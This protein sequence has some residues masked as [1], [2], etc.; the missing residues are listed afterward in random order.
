[1]YVMAVNMRVP[2]GKESFDHIPIEVMV[3]IVKTKKIY[4]LQDV[5]ERVW[6]GTD[7]NVRMFGP[8][9]CQIW[10]GDKWVTRDIEEI[11]YRMLETMCEGLCGKLNGLMSQED[12]SW[13][14]SIP[15]MRGREVQFVL[16]GLQR[17]IAMSGP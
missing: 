7:T 11:S 16:K 3:D 8:K 17:L 14:A 1:M 2:F 9:L 15:K 5:A 6:F 12:H 13:V 10:N 4:E